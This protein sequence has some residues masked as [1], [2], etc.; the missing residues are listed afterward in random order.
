[1]DV[2]EARGD[3]E[4]GSPEAD[5]FVFAY[6]KEVITHEVG[7]TLGMRHNFKSS[8]IYTA[9]QLRDK[10]FTSK[11]GIVGSVMDYPPFNLPVNGEKKADYI[12]PSLGPYDY[13]AIEYAYK[14]LD[15]K[16]EKGALD[17]IAARGSSE[18]WL[19]YGT[20][21][22]SFI[23]GTPQGMD[24]T[25]NVWDLSSNPLA[26]YR[27]RLDLSRE[28]WDRLQT[29]KLEDGESYDALRRSFLQGFSQLNRG[30]LPATKYI[31]GVVQLRD[32]AGSGRMPFTPVPAAQQREAL[33]ILSDGAFSVDSFKF[34]PEFL[35]S[36]PHNRLDYFDNLVR[37]DAVNTSPMVSVPAQI[38]T[39]QK[40]V[41]D[42][43]MSDGV[44]TR[45]IE[46]QNISTKPKEI[47][48]LSELYDNL[49][50]S[51]WSELKSG[52]EVT[53]MRRNLQRE[54]LRRVANAV[55][56]S[57]PAT[58]ADARALHRVN[59]QALA[60]EIRSAQ[61]KPG[62]SKETRAHLSEALNTLDEALKAPMM[63]VGV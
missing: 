15:A 49:Q 3:I 11:N 33:K 24:P 62:F 35:A 9:E 7:H 32:R 36:L 23:G 61:G 21:E 44:A 34:K 14:P 57:S 60:A 16:D 30:L 2:L 39:M 54:H 18:P 53:P 5:A 43:V 29:R 40:T 52:R 28:L 48:Q 12:M 25:V 22:D 38:L 59:A 46:A 17:K 4:P 19:A 6:V 1:M 51:I 37:G 26:Y 63:R 58:P 42:Q 47:F 31:G 45:I 8:T 50:A 13:W 41:L 27:K 20:D 56:R 55:L 10:E